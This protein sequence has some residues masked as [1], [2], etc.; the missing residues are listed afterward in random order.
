MIRYR[1]DRILPGEKTPT[2]TESEE[3]RPTRDAGAG[4]AAAPPAEVGICEKEL[5]AWPQTEQK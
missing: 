1:S 2:G 3:M 5:I 4:A